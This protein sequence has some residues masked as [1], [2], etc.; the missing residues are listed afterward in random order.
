MSKSS[1]LD[2]GELCMHH[3]H[4]RNTTNPSINQQHH[5]ASH[6]KSIFTGIPYAA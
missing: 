2:F 6:R 5:P 3:N 1:V 4:D